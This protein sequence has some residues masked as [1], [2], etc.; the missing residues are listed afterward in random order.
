MDLNVEADK[1]IFESECTVLPQ[2]DCGGFG[3]HIGVIYL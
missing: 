2:Q 1:G 3:L